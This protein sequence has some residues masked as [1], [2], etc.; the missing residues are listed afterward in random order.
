MCSDLHTLGIVSTR[1]RLRY[2][3]MSIFFTV[4]AQISAHG[5]FIH[6][7]LVFMGTRSLEFAAKFSLA[8]RDY[9][10]LSVTGY[11]F[12][13]ARCVL[14]FSL[15]ELGILISN[16]AIRIYQSLRSFGK[17]GPRRMSCLTFDSKLFMPARCLIAHYDC[18]SSYT[19]AWFGSLLAS[20]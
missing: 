16:H 2:D 12:G 3:K 20:H 6:P 17:H 14:K 8:G 19:R 4:F 7:N 11:F 9:S 15:N 18:Y 1:V 5:T 10:L 13:P